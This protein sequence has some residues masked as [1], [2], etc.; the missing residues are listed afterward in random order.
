VRHARASWRPAA[1][2][3]TSRAHRFPLLLALP[4]PT[5][6][7]PI[8]RVF[9]RFGGGPGDSVAQLYETAVAQRRAAEAPPA[10]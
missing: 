1:E 5:A 10:P 9:E 4:G 2:I 8:G 6:C 3:A 7:D